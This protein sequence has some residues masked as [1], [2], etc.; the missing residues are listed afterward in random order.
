MLCAILYVKQNEQY[1]VCS[2]QYYSIM[3]FNEH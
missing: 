1:V 2:D 3:S